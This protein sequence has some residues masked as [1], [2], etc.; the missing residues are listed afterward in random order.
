M[1]NQSPPNRVARVMHL[2]PRP[3]LMSLV[4]LSRS[5]REHGHAVKRFIIPAQGCEQRELPWVLCCRRVN[6]NAVANRSAQRKESCHCLLKLLQRRLAFFA[7]N[8]ARPA[9]IPSYRP[10]PGHRLLERFR[11]RTRFRRFRQPDGH[12]PG[13]EPGAPFIPRDDQRLLRQFSG[14]SR[15]LCRN[16]RAR[17]QNRY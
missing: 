10:A 17:R 2:G 1:K 11:S 13:F 14:G 3:F 9:G 6:R 5:G 8:V 7:Q 4:G 15:R 16:C 12:S